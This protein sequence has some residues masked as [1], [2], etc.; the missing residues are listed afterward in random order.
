MCGIAAA[1]DPQ[2]RLHKNVLASLAEALAGAQAHRGPDGAGLWEGPSCALAHRRLAVIDLSEGGAQPMRD[3]G[4][5]YTVSYNGEIYNFRE[6]RA[7]LEA[8][9]HAF[10]SRSDT[11][12]LLAAYAQWGERSFSRL[13]G[14]FAL[15]LH[16]A[17]E[18][19]LILARD[20]TG[21][22]PLYY[23]RHGGAW[24]AASE[25]RALAALPGF[26]VELDAQG[27]FDYLAL[28]YV[29]PPRT[30]LRGVTALQPGSFVAIDARGESEQRAYFAFDRAV[31]PMPRSLDEAA[32]AV[33]EALTAS[34]E[35]RLIADVPLGAFLSGGVDSGL[36]CALAARRLKRELRTFCAGFAGAADDETAAARR[37]AQALGL[38][39][40]SF[41]ISSDELL[42]LARGFGG[43]L[44]DPNGD[45]SCVPVYLLSREMR[46]EVT[47]AL[48]GDGGDELFC[49]YERYLGAVPG[50]EAYFERALPVFPPSLLKAVFPE[51]HAA[52]KEGFLSLYQPAMLRAG[53]NDAQR[54]SVVDFHSYLPGAVLA[55]VDRMA[56]RHALEVRTPFLEPRVMEV[57]ASLPPG[58]CLSPGV[59]K[60]V[61][62]HLLARYLPAELIAPGK[63]GFGM[64]PQFMKAHA[65]AFRALF[66]AACERLRSSA[67]FSAR[68]PAFE[69]LRGAAPANINS[70]WALTVLGMWC[71]AAGLA[72]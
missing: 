66:E 14:M 51:E 22:K 42:E 47:V 58:L 19:R 48:S 6:L 41:T 50:L 38:P 20:R 37:V 44:D 28:R 10:R 33:E 3:A 40:Q 17:R 65:P 23:A 29:P 57:A 30:I 55:K 26:P 43:A 61:L 8:L 59:L 56:M 68:P 9:G 16:D 72:G 39:H 11:E 18:R 31:D 7:E 1:F 13:D 36:V 5:R 70:T 49:G 4:G 12:V 2:A 15:A 52:W 25:L 24:V 62:R 45:R 71:E 46:R 67:F 34:L 64:P 54:M 63:T 32:D 27:V 69:A 35:R 60:P 53:W 21:E